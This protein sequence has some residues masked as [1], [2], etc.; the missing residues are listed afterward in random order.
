MESVSSPGTPK[1][2]SLKARMQLG[3][4]LKPPC[5][6]QHPQETPQAL[7][8]LWESQ[9]EA[10]PPHRMPA[11]VIVHITWKSSL[12]EEEKLFLQVNFNDLFCL[13]QYIQK[14]TI[15]TTS[16]RKSL[17]KSYFC[18][19]KSMNLVCILHSQHMLNLTSLISNATS[20]PVPSQWL[21]PGTEPGGLLSEAEPHPRLQLP[22]AGL[23][24]SE[25]GLAEP[26]KKTMTRSTW[27]K[28]AG[29]EAS[30]SDTSSFKTRI[31]NKSRERSV[32]L[33]KLHAPTLLLEVQES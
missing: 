4:K 23:S 8:G 27:G 6:P 28:G 1:R 26:E 22:G 15:S 12:I 33:Y 24:P 19:A 7:S 21:R 32:K 9:V 3:A 14:I 5:N 13:T 16:H 18:H 11:E 10:S 29:Q 20:L 17:I 2:H 25:T 30:A 31:K